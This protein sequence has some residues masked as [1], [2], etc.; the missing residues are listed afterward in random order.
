MRTDGNVAAIDC[1]SLSTRLLICSPGGLILERRMCLTGLGRGVWRAGAVSEE[2]VE[3]VL[4][5]LAQFRELMEDHEVRCAVMVGTSALRDASN[6]AD[7]SKRAEEVVGTR[8]R[9]L[10]GEEEASWSFVGA[11]KELPIEGS[12]WLVADIGGGSTELA[13]GPAANEEHPP[14]P[15]RSARSA[16]PAL[17]RAASVCSLQ[18]GCVRVTEQFFAHDPPRKDELDAARAWLLQQFASAAQAQ[19]AIA[20]ARSLVGLAGSVA[21]LACFDQDLSHYSREAVHHYV[22]SRSAVAGALASLASQPARERAGRPGIEEARAPFI[23]GGALILGALMGYFGFEDCTASE[24]D[25]LDG[26]VEAILSG[27]VG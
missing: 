4:G 8:L 1:G 7:F 2:A 24:S 15:Q 11:T 19:P 3:A 14:A 27:C 6:R 5:T 12:P 25:L 10:S 20:G 26:L 13:V 21:A 16:E 17:R 18:L 9:L 22:L 23:V